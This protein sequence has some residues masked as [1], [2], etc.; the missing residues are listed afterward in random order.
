MK[1]F[2]VFCAAKLTLIQFWK[3]LGPRINQVGGDVETLRSF[4]MK[5]KIVGAA[6][7]N[8]SATEIGD[9]LSAALCLAN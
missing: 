6:T 9:T 4:M 7:N 3:Q 8:T 5:L 1:C 2:V